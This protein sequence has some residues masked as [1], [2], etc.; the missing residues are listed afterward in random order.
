MIDCGDVQKCFTEFKV[1][2]KTLKD[3]KGGKSKL[4][5]EN[6]TEKKF[7]ILDIENCVY[8]SLKDDTK[9]DY[10]I[11]DDKNNIFYFIELKGCDVNKGIKQIL[12]T[13]KDLKHHINAEK[14]KARLIVTRFPSPKSTFNTKDYKD[15]MKIVNQDLIIKNSHTEII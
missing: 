5:I 14:L 4:L 3:K 7:K 2:K 6:P 9:C 12:E 15:L 13:I 10:G 8:K 1:K 11:L